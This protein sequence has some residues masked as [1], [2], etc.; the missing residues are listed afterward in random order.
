MDSIE[1]TAA[2]ILNVAKKIFQINEENN[3]QTIFKD[4]I[5]IINGENVSVE[6][7]DCKDSFY[8]F[9]SPEIDGVIIKKENG[10]YCIKATIQY[11]N[12]RGENWGFAKI[13]IHDNHGDICINGRRTGNWE[14]DDF[15]DVDFI[16]NPDSEL[17]IVLNSMNNSLGNMYEELNKNVEFGCNKHISKQI[18][19]LIKYNIN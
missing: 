5:F 15:E 17:S 11:V 4:N 8:Y 1:Q 9:E 7:C 2:C 10:D 3:P 12:S 6:Y 18:K 13:R 16:K 19:Q 14:M